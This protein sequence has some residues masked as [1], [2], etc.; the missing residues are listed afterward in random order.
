[1]YYT[2]YGKQDCNYCKKAVQLLQS[3]MLE[4]VYHDV[5]V[6]RQVYKRMQDAVEKSTGRF[7]ETVPQIFV[8]GTYV[9]GYTELAASLEAK[10]EVV[11]P[12]DFNIGEL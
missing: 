5:L 12:D 3:K 11:S 6:D 10:K 4:F 7:A 2:V 9:G 1:M 8:D